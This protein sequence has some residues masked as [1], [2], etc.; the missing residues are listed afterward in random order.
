MFKKLFAS[1]V[2]TLSILA[3]AKA[4]AADAINQ[5]HQEQCTTVPYQRPDANHL[6]I[7]MTIEGKELALV[8]DTGAQY[9]IVRRNSLP[10]AMPVNG[11]AGIGSQK[12]QLYSLAHAK[13]QL[14][15][16]NGDVKV[17]TKP[18]SMT[19]LSGD[20]SMLPD[21]VDGI[22]GIDFMS[23]FASTSLNFKEKTMSFCQ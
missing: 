4:Y 11:Q 12:V 10:G 19:V 13:V 23:S 18:R 14:A 22:V 3:S 8:V 7:K 5:D 21:K 9:T 2:L 16:V 6:V 1:L 17:Q 20:M 15:D